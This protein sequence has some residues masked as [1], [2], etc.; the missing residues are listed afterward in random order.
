MKPETVHW[1]LTMSSN[2]KKV[3]ADGAYVE[4]DKLVLAGSKDLPEIPLQSM[5]RVGILRRFSRVLVVLVVI[6]AVISIFTQELLHTVLTL[7]ML[8]VCLATREDVLVVETTEGQLIEISV[9]D[10]R[11]VKKVSEELR[12]LL[13]R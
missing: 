4:G 10:R 9:R 1:G 8:G 11:S 7:I 13:T 5:R 2:A 3:K 12:R 6:M